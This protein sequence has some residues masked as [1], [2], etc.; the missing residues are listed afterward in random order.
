MSRW[1]LACTNPPSGGFPY[2]ISDFFPLSGQ[3]IDRPEAQQEI[4]VLDT[5]SIRN[6][7]TYISVNG[8]AGVA[9]FI[10]RVN[11]TSTALAIAI[12]NQQ[13]GRFQDL[14]NSVNIVSGDLVAY[15]ENRSGA[16]PGSLPRSTSISV[17][18]RSDSGDITISAT[19]EGATI[20]NTAPEYGAIRGQVLESASNTRVDI[21]MRNAPTL[22]DMRFYTS[23][24]TLDVDPTVSLLKN[25]SAANQSVTPTGTGAFEDTSNTDSFLATDEAATKIDATAA[26][27]GSMSPRIIHYKSD[28]ADQRYSGSSEVFRVNADGNDDFGTI[29]GY[30]INVTIEAD[31]QI[32]FQMGPFTL[33]DFQTNVWSN[34]NTTTTNIFLRVNGSDSSVT[35]AVASATTGIFEDTSNTQKIVSG[36]LVN[37]RGNAA[38]GTGVCFNGLAISATTPEVHARNWAMLI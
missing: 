10:L 34:S 26:S 4:K 2:G 32:I 35:I 21:T 38:S 9:N 20:G 31:T 24:F 8:L 13:T 6:M 22:S 23:A 19:S 15:H 36:D 11:Q 27:S 37:Y 29:E 3:L 14:A 33:K 25:G 30:D 18:M 16:I 1:L 28:A 5:Y 7:A 12:P 17:E